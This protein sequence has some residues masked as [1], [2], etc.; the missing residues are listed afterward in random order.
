MSTRMERRLN[1]SVNMPAPRMRMF[2]F[3]R[4]A[5]LTS[6]L[7]ASRRCTTMA[8]TRSTPT[9]TIATIVPLPD[10]SNPSSL[11]QGSL[12]EADPRA[13]E[14]EPA[15]AP[16]RRRALPLRCRRDRQP[17]AEHHHRSERRAGPEDPAPGPVVNEPRLE[18][19][20]DAQGGEQLHRV[21]ADPVDGE[22]RG[23]A[24]QRVAQRQRVERP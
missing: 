5:G 11:Y 1:R 9:A 15:P 6:G 8:I 18:R 16:R 24:A 19:C 21:G 2:R 3:A 4:M 22:A 10:T 23:K 14:A 7:G 17:D 20:A 13:A 12:Q